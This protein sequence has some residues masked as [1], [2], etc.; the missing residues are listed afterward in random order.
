MTEDQYALPAGF[1]AECAGA[2]GQYVTDRFGVQ[3]ALLTQFELRVGIDM[4]QVHG[5]MPVFLIGV[6]VSWFFRRAG[7]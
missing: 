1:A 2:F 4:P 5:V 3:Q 6:E 7:G